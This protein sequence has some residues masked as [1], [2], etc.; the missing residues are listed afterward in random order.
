MM[1]DTMF[2]CPKEVEELLIEKNQ[3]HVSQGKVKI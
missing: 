3:I 2:G 1:V